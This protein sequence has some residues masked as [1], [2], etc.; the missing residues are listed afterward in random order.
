MAD[1]LFEIPC[2][3]CKTILIIR[4]RDGKLIEARA[5]IIEDST[6]DR[7]ED[8]FKKVKRS[9]GEIERKVAEAKERERTKMDR[10]NA[11]FKEGMEQAQKEGPV[12]PPRRD[13]DLD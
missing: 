4:R 12:K 7:F 2:P 1:E 11:L 3:G 5:P 13:M 8:A 6:G 9:Q 10:L